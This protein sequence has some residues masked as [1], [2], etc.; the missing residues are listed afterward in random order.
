[1]NDSAAVNL[2]L[3]T[4]GVAGCA[5][6]MV[7]EQNDPTNVGWEGIAN[8]PITTCDTTTGISVAFSTGDAGI[9]DVR[10]TATIEYRVIFTSTFST[11]GDASGRIASDYFEVVYTDPCYGM[12]ITLTTGVSDVTYLIHSTNGVIP[13]AITAPTFSATSTCAVTDTIYAKLSS[14]DEDA[15]EDITDVGGVDYTIIGFTNANTA[16]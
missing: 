1:M 14:A 3:P 16:L 4:Q 7:C 9:D 5:Y 15:W 10:P 12:T 2:F 11:V 8:P 6:T 13:M